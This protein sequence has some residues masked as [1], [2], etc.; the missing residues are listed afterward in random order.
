MNEELHKIMAEIT[1]KIMAEAVENDMTDRM[2][3]AQRMIIEAITDLDALETL[4]L[5]GMFYFAGKQTLSKKM[6]EEVQLID[7]LL[8]QQIWAL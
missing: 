1:E 8:K 5:C 2:A 3:K 6:P 4:T 7:S